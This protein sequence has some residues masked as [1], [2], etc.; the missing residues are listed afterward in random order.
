MDQPGT[1]RELRLHRGCI[2]LEPTAPRGRYAFRIDGNHLKVDRLAKAEQG[3]VSPHCFVSAARVGRDAET[4]VNKVGSLIQRARDHQ[5]VEGNLRYDLR[6]VT[7]VLTSRQ[8]TFGQRPFL[9][10]PPFRARRSLRRLRR[11]GVA[12][13]REQLLLARARLLQVGLLDVLEAANLLGKARD[14]D[15]DRVIVMV[16]RGEQLPYALLVVPDQ[17]AFQ[18]AM[19]LVAENVEW[20]PAQP[21]EPRQEREGP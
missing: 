7:A 1:G 12:K 11:R 13:G 3:V 15:G 19:P 20:R 21:L 5:V 9:L 14:L 16:E 8:M 6:H 18:P 4:V 2:E 17:P 10:Q